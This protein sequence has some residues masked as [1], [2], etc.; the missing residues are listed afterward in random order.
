L[1]REPLV[2]VCIPTYNRARWIREA[3]ES[4]LAQTYQ[5]LEVLVV[6]DASSDDTE[7][8]VRALDDPRVRFVANERNLGMVGNHNRTLQ[9]A[10]GPLIKF[11]HADDVLA[12]EC[13][14]RMV[15]RALR[16]DRVG[17][18]FGPRRVELDGPAQPDDLAWLA[19]YGT[20]HEPLGPLEPVNAGRPL[21]ERWLRGILRE[22]GTEN[23]LGEPSAV[24]LR[25]SALERVGLFNERLSMLIEV[26]LWLR[27]VFF[28]DV[29][30]VDAALSTYRHHSSS[31]TSDLAQSGRSWL[32]RLWLLE[33]LLAHR[34]IR[35]AHPEL[36]RARAVEA[37]WAA[38]LLAG[39]AARRRPLD[40]GSLAA[41]ASFLARR[42]RPPLHPQLG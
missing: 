4:A 32:D 6:D 2:T 22:R 13:V 38:R 23:W 3:V 19:Q 8:V 18:V 9:L 28:F 11:L 24:L 17:L 42:P 12:P 10:D 21:F 15:E 5:N 34:E 27:I 29:G 16:S 26:E 39:R 35:G 40:I 20:L 41:Y 37:A 33:G 25:R 7:S 30:F 1:P 36:R 14:E 31:A